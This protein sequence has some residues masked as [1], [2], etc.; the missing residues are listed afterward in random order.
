MK[1]Y[2]SPY[3]FASYYNQ[4]IYTALQGSRIGEAKTEGS[5]ARFKKQSKNFFRKSHVLQPLRKLGD[6]GYLGAE[7]KEIFS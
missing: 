2:N 7:F 1:L 4:M 3:A 5:T 6:I